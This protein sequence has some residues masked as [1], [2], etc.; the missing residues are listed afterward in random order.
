MIRVFVG[1]AEN[2]ADIEAQAALEWSIRKHT[3]REVSVT[4][5]QAIPETP[6]HGWNRGRWTTPFSGFRWSVPELCDFAGEAIY[7]DSD[8]LFLSD[9]GELWDQPFKPSKAVIAKGAEHGQ[10]L[11]V[12]KWNCSLAHEFLPPLSELKREATAHRRLMEWFARHQER[13][14]P[15]DGGDWNCLDLEPFDLNAPTTKAVHYTG[16][17]TQ[18][19]LKY[20][21][22][23][24]AGEGKSHWYGGPRREHPRPELQTLFDRY[25]AEAFENGFT[26][27]RYRI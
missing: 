7:T 22:P 21:L 15:F 5:M 13:V 2:N 3:A 14:Q 1:C 10:R 26:L 20:A 4:W 19:H 8:V 27:E 25:L 23:R 9:I 11:C 6:W 24:L 16:I 18:P 12:C 17:P